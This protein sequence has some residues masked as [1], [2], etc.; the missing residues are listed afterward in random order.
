MLPVDLHAN[1]Q[2]QHCYRTA[3]YMPLRLRER[4]CLV[5]WVNILYM[6]YGG[7]EQK[8]T[9]EYLVGSVVR[10]KRVGTALKGVMTPP[11][12]TAS[13]TSNALLLT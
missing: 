10:A 9:R 12:N 7:V 2:A 5:C 8:G 11:R 1:A 6:L 3:R 4:A 13:I